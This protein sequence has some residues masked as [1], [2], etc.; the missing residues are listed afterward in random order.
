MFCGHRVVA[1]IPARGGSK[2]IPKKNLSK[3]GGKS[4][5]YWSIKKAKEIKEID[6]IAVS[7]DCKFI[8]NEA[9]LYGAEVM[10]RPKNLATDDSKVIDTLRDIIN[11]F[12][13]DGFNND[14]ILLIEPTSPFRNSEDI[15][16]CIK[17]FEDKTVESVATFTKSRTHPSKIWRIIN[18]EPQIYLEGENAFYSRQQLDKTWELNGACYAFLA[19]KLPNKGFQLLFGKSRAVIMPEE[20]SL[21]INEEFDL[22]F[23]NSLLKKFKGVN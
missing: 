23:A 19:N 21:D 22:F 10:D 11:K 16:K 2:G 4:L 9:I 14:I 12:K 13:K 20:R 15:V 17:C 1:I 6:K 5:L 18:E 8:K 7:T 3:L